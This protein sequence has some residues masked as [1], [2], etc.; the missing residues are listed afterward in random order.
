[1]SSHFRNL[2]DLPNILKL[3]NRKKDQL[4][5]KVDK[6]IRVKEFG[7]NLYKD[8]YDPNTS[9]KKVI[10]EGKGWITISRQGSR[11]EKN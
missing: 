11:F 5:A 3:Y 2:K 9:F 4:N 8:G 7:S 1:M 6:W 10:V